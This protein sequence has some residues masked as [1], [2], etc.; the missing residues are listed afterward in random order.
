MRTSAW[1]DASGR[2]AGGE[3]RATD[4]AGR[5]SVR[6]GGAARTRTSLKSTD[7]GGRGAEASLN[8]AAWFGTAGAFG[9]EVLPG[10]EVRRP[11]G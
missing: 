10:L 11:A 7:R 9:R 1:L 8:V 3:Q 5:V 4:H 6:L 2:L